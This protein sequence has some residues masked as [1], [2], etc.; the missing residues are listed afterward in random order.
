MFLGRAVVDNQMDIE[1]LFRFT[2]EFYQKALELI[3]A[4][5]GQAFPDH[6]VPS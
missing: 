1:A 6:T 2:V 4:M 5:S 3:I